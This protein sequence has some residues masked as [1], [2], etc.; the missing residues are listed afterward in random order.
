MFMR[1]IPN[2]TFKVEKW[3]PNAGAKSKLDTSWFRIIGIPLEKRSEKIASYVGSLVGIRLEVDKGNLRRW[4]Y[5]R[6]RIGCRDVKKLP[7]SVEGLLDLHFY[8]FTFK[9]EV[10]QA[11]VTNASGTT[12]TRIDDRS[13]EDNPSPKEPKRSDG[14]DSQSR[15][16][17]DQGANTSDIGK[18]VRLLRIWRLIKKR[19]SRTISGR[20]Y[21]IDRN[22]EEVQE[23]SQPRDKKVQNAKPDSKV[24]GQEHELETIEEESED[25]GLCFDDL[26][27][28]GGEH[29]NFGSFQQ[30]E[31]KQLSSVKLHE[32][33][34]TMIN[35][36]GTNMFK[37]KFDPLTVIEAKNDLI[38][39]KSSTQTKQGGV[40][41]KSPSQETREPP[42]VWSSQEEQ[43]SNIQESEIDY[44]ELGLT[45]TQEGMQS[46]QVTDQNMDLDGKVEEN[47]NK[48]EAEDTIEESREELKNMGQSSRIKNQG[49]D[50]LKAS[51]KAE[52]LKRK[53]NLEGNTLDTQELIYRANLMGVNTDNLSLETFDILR[54]LENAR[55]NL[56]KRNTELS[57]EPT[58][59]PQINLPSEE[60]K[61]IDWKSDSLNKEGFQM[62]VSKREIPQPSDG[63]FS[64]KRDVPMISSR[65]NLRKCAA[66]NKVN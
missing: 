43:W 20:E 32:N 63:G 19:M 41:T 31:V 9:R 47:S 46:E 60:I 15:K 26:I 25:Q 49:M 39:G 8:E 5:V 30:I 17:S 6:V 21:V 52:R 29:F 45:Q 16:N 44:G 42:V 14:G 1:T 33:T 22:Q 61:Y 38:F 36:Y 53:H 23:S 56:F 12:W 50:G 62:S 59:E 2:V 57:T 58:D 35:E 64:L 48:A 34:S 4:D 54:E 28:P 65:Y 10:P 7:A 24:M 3:N 55:S 40:E 51:E 18:Q 37:S 66:K 11:G 13:N 27:S